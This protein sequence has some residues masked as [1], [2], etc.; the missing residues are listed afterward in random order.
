MHNTLSAAATLN[1]GGMIQGARGMMNTRNEEE[2]DIEQ[3]RR[4]A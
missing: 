4:R 1:V 3:D 2:R